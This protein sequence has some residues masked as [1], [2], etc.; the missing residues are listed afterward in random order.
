[1]G[2]RVPDL[3]GLFLRGHGQQA[4]SQENGSTVGMTST[5]HSS[6]ALGQIQGDASR[7]IQGSFRTSNE[8]YLSGAS[9]LIS[10][11]RNG[12]IAWGDSMSHHTIGFDSSRVVPTAEEIRPVNTAVRYLVRAL[13]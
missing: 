1:M 6:G 7:E 2:A 3:Q 9:Y 5:L 11:N 12:N 13:K 4:H 10:F 8:S